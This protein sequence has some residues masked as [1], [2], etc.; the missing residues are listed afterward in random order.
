M[1]FLLVTC[2]FQIFT[3]IQGD[4]CF[5]ICVLVNT[6][7]VCVYFLV[8]VTCS[9]EVLTSIRG[10]CVD[11]ARCVPPIPTQSATLNLKHNLLNPDFIETHLGKYRGKCCFLGGLIQR[12][13]F[14]FCSCC[15][16][17]L[18]IQYSEL[19]EIVLEYSTNTCV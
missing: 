18:I 19:I 4:L 15:T 9:V 11:L 16:H 10:E 1:D 13:S 8:L 2:G 7:F 14:D 17:M 5:C 12:S 6:V 3:S